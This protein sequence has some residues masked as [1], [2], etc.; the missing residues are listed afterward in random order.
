VPPRRLTHTAIPTILVIDDHSDLRDALTVLL[1]TEGYRVVDAGNGAEALEHL[2]SADVH[3]VIVDLDM[4]VMNGWEF[5]EACRQHTAWRTIPTLIVTGMTI[6]ER[7]QS[8]L[9]NVVIFRKPFGFDELL[10]A[11][12]R[13]MIREVPGTA[14]TT[15]A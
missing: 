7:R 2:R 5:L 12:R 9:G 3:G 11:V 13:V 15:L 14:T 10:A 4:P 8:E 6:D 1:E